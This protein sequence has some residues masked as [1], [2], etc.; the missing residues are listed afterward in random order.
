[1]VT[2]PFVG[3]FKIILGFLISSIFSEELLSGL[4]SSS[5]RTSSEES[6]T[7][8]SILI[9]SV[10]FST[11]IEIESSFWNGSISFVSSSPIKLII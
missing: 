5:L 11:G 2:L 1:M 7:S 8:S 6:S 10:G 9:F 3:S 4:I